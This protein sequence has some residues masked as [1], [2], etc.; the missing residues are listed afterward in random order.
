MISTC[1]LFALFDRSVYPNPGQFPRL[2]L[3][4]S[5]LF[6]LLAYSGSFSSFPALYTVIKTYFYF[7]IKAFNVI[8]STSFLLMCTSVRKQG[9]GEGRANYC[10][11]NVSA[12]LFCKERK[13]NYE[14][15]KMTKIRK[16]YESDSLINTKIFMRGTRGLKT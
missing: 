12:H 8:A 14:E 16:R 7:L 3:S 5:L 4:L 13:C 1:F 6:S 9:A 2:V 15:F 11:Y 10:C